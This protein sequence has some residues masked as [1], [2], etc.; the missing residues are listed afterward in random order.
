MSN[1]L[2]RLFSLILG[3]V[4]VITSVPLNSSNAKGVNVKGVNVKEASVIG[5]N[6]ASRSSSGSRFKSFFFLI[7][8]P[9]CS[10]SF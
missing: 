10:R 4:K 5:A 8:E 9:I 7:R 1:I 2:N 6:I 3:L